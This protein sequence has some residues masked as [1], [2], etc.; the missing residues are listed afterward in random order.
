MAD[1]SALKDKAGRAAVDLVENGMKLGIGT[2]S[3]AEAFIRV[4]GQRVAGGL[5]VKGVA[6][7][8][9]TA[10]LCRKLSIPIVTL[11]DEPVLDLA[12]DGADEID[13]ALGLVK[14]GG[15]ALLREKIVAAA[16]GRFVVIA[17]GAK[18][19]EKLGAFPLPIEINGF[20]LMSTYIAICKAAERL[21]LDAAVS[22]RRNGEE[23]FIT[24][25]GHLILDASFGLI[26]DSEAV[27][28][29]LHDIPGVVEHGL[30]LGLATV[31]IVA[32]EDRVETLHPRGAGRA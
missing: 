17:D 15:G 25:G 13:P 9:R 1:T 18:L 8:E 30:F 5:K 28:R 19:V 11:E 12:I 22:L 4:L 29:A 23:P 7:S 24:D 6:T 26:P 27:S 10:V 20:G 21:G 14:G 31:A 3:T 2:G 32:Y 16:S